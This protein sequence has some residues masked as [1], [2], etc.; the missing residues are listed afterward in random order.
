[1][2]LTST[3]IS[4]DSKAKFVLEYVDINPKKKGYVR[5]ETSH[6]NLNL[7]L[8][9]DLTPRACENFITHCE[10]GYYNSTM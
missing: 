10:A 3:S 4:F 7:E 8:H 2:S 1:M 5:L 6:G 9:C